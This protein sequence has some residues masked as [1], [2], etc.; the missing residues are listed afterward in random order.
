MSILTKWLESLHEETKITS[1]CT[2]ERNRHS[3]CS[4]CLDQC[5]QEAIIFK[6]HLLVIDMNN[7]TMCGD[8]LVSCPLSAIDGLATSRVFNKGSLVFDD[9]YT[10]SLKELLIYKKRGMT[11]VEAKQTHINL[12][13]ET[14]I[15]EANKRL[16]I[17]GDTQIN[18]IMKPSDEKFSRRALFESFQTEGKQLAKS[19]APASWK[20]D[21][22]GWKLSKYF[23]GFQFYS[24]E[25]NTNHCTLCQAC[26]SIC[27]EDVFTIM[28]SRLQIDNEKCVSCTFCTDICPEKAIHIYEDLRMKSEKVEMFLKKNCK[29]CGQTFNTFH[30]E[31]EKCHVCKDRDPEWLSPY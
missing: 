14:V 22:D 15:A 18:L 26:F 13:W 19:L 17:L 7:C 25:L 8:C 11:S 1:R 21:H 29:S 6:E 9:A 12:E 5:S 16:N 27:P 20:M 10:P 23:P 28:D 4:I 2:R 3:T 24:V 30:N 31:I